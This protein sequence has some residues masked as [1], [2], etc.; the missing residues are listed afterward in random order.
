MIGTHSAHPAR[1]AH[2]PWFRD[3]DACERNAGLLRQ[4]ADDGLKDY[5]DGAI[6]RDPH[7][8]VKQSVKMHC[9]I[10][11]IEVS[12]GSGSNKPRRMHVLKAIVQSQSCFHSR[13]HEN[14][15]ST[16]SHGPPS[17]KHV[18]FAPF[19]WRRPCDVSVSQG[20]RSALPRNGDVH[21]HCSCG[22][23]SAPLP[24]W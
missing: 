21:D 9:L 22:S 24:G 19:R 4:A 13:R 3:P 2:I 16:K 8:E 5:V 14:S 12:P 11:E 23:I 10:L 18:V 1:G 6:A 20:G 15:C 7:R 17:L